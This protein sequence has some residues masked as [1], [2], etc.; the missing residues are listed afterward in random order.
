MRRTSTVVA[1]LGAVIALAPLSASAQQPNPNDPNNN[2]P[3]AP[4]GG[5]VRFQVVGAGGGGPGGGGGVMNFAGGNAIVMPAGPMMNRDMLAPLV[6]MLGE[7]NL[8]PDFNLSGEQKQKIQSIRDDFK[9][10]TEAFKKDHADELKQLDD[11]QKELMD[12]FQNGNIP[13]PGAMMEL[14]E[15]R[16]ALMQ[17]APDG[18]EHA[19]QI[20]ALL[21]PDQ[22]KKLEEK[23]AVAAKER[24]EMQA[25]FP[26]M[27]MGG[28]G[29]APPAPPN[30]PAA[31][32]PPA[33][34]DKDGKGR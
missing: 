28:P 12:G 20:K 13:D 18:G 23:E 16:R 17:N 4:G 14:M 24:E 15:Q 31:P 29:M 34:K 25:R 2:A 27:R 21:T 1:A 26:M 30:A 5:A 10:A 7:L 22:T 6:M 19:T 32:N 8:S 33:E 9:G 3:A 11:Q